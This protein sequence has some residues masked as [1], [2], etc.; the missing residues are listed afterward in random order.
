[1]LR[2]L[3]GLVFRGQA[4]DMKVGEDRICYYWFD[5]PGGSG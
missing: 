3:L 4:K 1:M 5:Y 2:F